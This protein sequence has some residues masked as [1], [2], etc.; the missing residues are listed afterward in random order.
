[1]TLLER[2]RQLAERVLAR[3]SELLETLAAIRTRLRI[4][5]VRQR[6]QVHR[7]FPAPVKR[8]KPPRVLAVVTHLSREGRTADVSAQRLAETLDG[9]LASLG[10]TDLQLALNTLPGRHVA[11]ALPAYQRERLLVCEQSP[12]GDPLFLGFD[13]QNVFAERVDDYDWFCFLE[14]DLI[15][16]D[17]I[18]LEKLA[19]FND[20][21]PPEAVLLPHRYELWNGQK[22]HID[23]RAKGR[24]GEDTTA[25]RLTLIEA[26][27]WKFAEPAN[28]HS[29]FYALT[30]SQV[31]TWL[32]SGRHWY[33]LCSYY[34]PLESAATG[35]LEE[36]F[37]IY[38]PHPDNLEFLEIRHFGTKYAE[39]YEQLAPRGGED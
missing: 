29:G 4:I 3:P 17:G 33:K 27:D 24:A 12:D 13:A 23:M 37:R 18:L 28:P 26:G 10:H 32:A 25:G 6:A 31:R 5:R 34:G 9:L 30:Q 35:S 19:F 22:I 21:A 39:L 15:L 8:D 11:D 36:C 1:M 14:D 38:K 20:A 7:R 2:G 16:G